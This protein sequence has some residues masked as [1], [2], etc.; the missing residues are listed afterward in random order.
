MRDHLAFEIVK[1]FPIEL[2]L[3]EVHI[4]WFLN[5]FMKS[6]A[7]FLQIF[8]Q[9]LKQLLARSVLEVVAIRIR[10]LEHLSALNNFVQRLSQ[11]FQLVQRV[12]LNLMQKLHF[13][14]NWLFQLFRML[15]RPLVV[16]ESLK[17][18]HV[19][20]QLVLEILTLVILLNYVVVPRLLHI[21][22]FVAVVISAGFLT[23]LA[24]C[25]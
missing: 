24:P 14:L 13:A 21:L 11:E 22:V 2:V 5:H 19:L 1:W 25:S 12:L 17:I 10:P 15:F 8:L 7:V 9:E 16:V 4:Q 23:V 20:A 18:E 3:I 6:F